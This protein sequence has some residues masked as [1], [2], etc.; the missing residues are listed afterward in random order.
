[1]KD[2]SWIVRR[3]LAG[4]KA[5]SVEVRKVCILSLGIEDVMVGAGMA[6][7][8]ARRS[9]GEEVG[10]ML[11]VVQ[12]SWYCDVRVSEVEGLGWIAMALDQK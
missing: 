9:M 2:P 6:R 4:T 10:G 5:P 12:S 8:A 7:R 1:M 3:K 11:R